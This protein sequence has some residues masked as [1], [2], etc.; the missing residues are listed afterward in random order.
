MS[1][2]KIQILRERG[3]LPRDSDWRPV[4]GEFSLQLSPTQAVVLVEFFCRC[5]GMM[6]HDFLHLVLIELGIGL[7]HLHP[8]KLL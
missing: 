1:R 4:E 5:F 2:E 8:D 7:H 3:L 6:A